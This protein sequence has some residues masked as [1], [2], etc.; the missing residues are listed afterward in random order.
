MEANLSISGKRLH[1]LVV[2]LRGA[3]GLQGVLSDRG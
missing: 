2:E 3:V 1:V